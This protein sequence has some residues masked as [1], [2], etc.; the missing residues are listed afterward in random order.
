LVL[1]PLDGISVIPPRSL[2]DSVF[3]QVQFNQKERKKGEAETEMKF[4]ESLTALVL[5]AATVGAVADGSEKEGKHHHK[6]VSGLPPIGTGSHRPHHTPKPS[7]SHSGHH[8][9]PTAS[10][11]ILSQSY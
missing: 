6:S 3:L 11:H 10:Q 5:L 2:V 4:F 8:S 7:H 9:K 1:I